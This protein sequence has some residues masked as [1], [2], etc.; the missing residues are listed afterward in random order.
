MARPSVPTVVTTT[1]T[2]SAKHRR[3]WSAWRLVSTTAHRTS[4]TVVPDPDREIP[5]ES[6]R[7]VEQR[8]QMRCLGCWGRGYE[9]HHRRSRRVREAHRHCACN[10]VL[11]CRTCHTAA[12]SHHESGR[13]RGLI[14][15]QWIDEPFMVPVTDPMGHWWVLLC[16]G[17][18][19][20][21]RPDQI[22]TDGFG[23][24]LVVAEREEET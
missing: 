22:E 2:S 24:F 5:E 13:E 23:G 4:G 20:P 7:L 18:Y 17:R 9:W 3:G 16:D 12:H 8:Q 10:G 11:L 15:S 6:R 1:T 14:V 21:L 19:R